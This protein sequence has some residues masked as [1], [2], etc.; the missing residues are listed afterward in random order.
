M[1]VKYKHDFMMEKV[2]GKAVLHI[3]AT[4]YPYHIDRAKKKDLLHQKLD[5]FSEKLV[6]VDINK[7]AIKDIAKFGVNNIFYGN[8]ITGEF[9]KRIYDCKYDIILFPD[10]LEHLDNPGMALQQLKKIKN[11]NTSIIITIP[12]VWSIFNF[13][14]HFRSKEVVHKDH[15]FWT[16]VSTM[17]TMLLNNGFKIVGHG[18]LYYNSYKRQNLRG[19]IFKR[20]FIDTYPVF[21][22][23]LFFEVK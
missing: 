11:K 6:G 17:R 7:K 20:I 1:V 8:V 13:L 15:C 21:A 22:P 14:N 16:S 3:G 5:I 4:D 12:N 2:K 19:K 18:Y 10:V 23:T 9:D